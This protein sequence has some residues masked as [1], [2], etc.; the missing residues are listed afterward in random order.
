VYPNKKGDAGDGGGGGGV[1]EQD[2]RDNVYIYVGRYEKDVRH[3]CI[4]KS[5]IVVTS[6][7]ILG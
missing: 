2:I 7:K 6:H 1:K 5:F 3:S 4:M